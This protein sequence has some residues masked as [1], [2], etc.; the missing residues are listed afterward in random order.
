MVNS[1]PP[2]YWINLERSRARRERMERAL[3]QH[4]LCAERVA[5]VDGGD[6]ASVD[7]SIR[8]RAVAPKV[9]A[10]LA[11]HL[12]AIRLAYA[13]AEPCALFMEDDAS[14]ELLPR[15][16]GDFRAFFGALP[17]RWSAIYLGYGDS[18][19]RLDRLFRT[20]GLLVPVPSLT[21]WSTVAYA[22]QREAMGYLLAAF[23]RGTHF[24]VSGFRGAHEADTVLLHSLAA[25][26]ALPYPQVVRVPMF[27]FLGQD[28]EIHPEDLPRQQRARAFILDAFDELAAGRYQPRFG[29]A[30]RLQ[31]AR[32]LFD[33]LR[34]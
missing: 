22:L 31:R 5:A 12:S 14:F 1:F 2:I 3:A 30:A 25:A 23:D 13:R 6:P 8:A 26:R 11:S 32:G 7:R 10:C 21:L 33:A 15:W 28:S 29:L 27:T 19:A 18:P 4:G 9:A 20:A 34:R 16:P 24:D 17:A